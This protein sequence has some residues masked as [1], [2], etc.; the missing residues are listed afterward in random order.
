MSAQR[1]VTYWSAALV[2]FAILIPGSQASA[3]VGPY[4]ES[5]RY[6]AG[7]PF[8]LRRFERQRYLGTARPYDYRQSRYYAG[9]YDRSPYAPQSVAAR[10]SQSYAREGRRTVQRR[11]NQLGFDAGPADGVYGSRTR[12]AMAAFQSSIGAAPTGRLTSSQVALLYDRSRTAP[13]R[14]T[15]VRAEP[16]EPA[17][18]V[19]PAPT[20]DPEPQAAEPPETDVVPDAAATPSE[21]TAAAP[22]P[23]AEPEPSESVASRAPA[24][25]RPFDDGTADTEPPV[26]DAS[27]DPEPNDEATETIAEVDQ[28]PA[29]GPVFTPEGLPIDP[30]TGEAAGSDTA[31]SDTPETATDTQTA[32]ADPEPVVQEPETAE[33]DQPAAEEPA[34]RPVR[35]VLAQ[36][37]AAV[38][39]PT[40]DDGDVNTLPPGVLPLPMP[41]GGLVASPF[42]DVDDVPRV[43]GLAPGDPLSEVKQGLAQN[44]YRNCAETGETVVCSSSNQSMTDII[45]IA[46]A[47]VEAD[48]PAYLIRRKLAF[49]KPVRRSFLERQMAGRYPD[50]LERPDGVISISETC[51][52][53]ASLDPGADQGDPLQALFNARKGDTKPEDRALQLIETCPNLYALV[54]DGDDMVSNL[55][56]VLFD[57]NAMGAR[58]IAAVRNPPPKDSEDEKEL[59]E[60][61]RF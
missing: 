58:G 3:Q 59:G 34:D 6:G 41:R 56:I 30:E 16:D 47:G 37:T 19:I 38:D 57:T 22:E 28:P 31:A 7:G 36:R 4:Y 39:S 2:A 15:P 46:Y 17:P 49:K 25:T 26:T 29:V 5:P 27:D 23:E 21:D 8:A 54:F 18:T 12:A 10:S 35:T 42:D 20:P 53:F 24:Y 60:T 33:L 61:L 51:A 13:A 14:P 43:F 48:A 52:A 9:P 1:A 11:L 55:E 44:G 40:I 32:Q 45:S 50:L